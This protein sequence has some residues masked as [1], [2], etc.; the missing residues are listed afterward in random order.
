VLT[1]EV[2]DARKI[3]RNRAYRVDL[4]VVFA[5][6]KCGDF[7]QEYVEALHGLGKLHAAVVEV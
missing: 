7:I 1:R 4:V 5:V 2:N 6:R 3:G